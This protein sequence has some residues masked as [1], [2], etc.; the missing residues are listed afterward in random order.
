MRLFTVA[1]ILLIA[2]V[3]TTAQRGYEVGGWLGVSHYFG[4]LNT[5]YR[6]DR[7]GIAG[8]LIGRY[9]FNNRLSTKLSLNY[10]RLSAYDSDSDNPFQRARNLSFR[11]PVI[12]GT[13]QFEF[14][15]FPYEHGSDDYYFTP[16][17]FG[18]VSAYYSNPQAEYEGQ[19]YELQSLGTEGQPIGGEYVRVQPALAYGI[20][21][22]ADLNSTWSINV[23]MS[24][25][26]LFS[27]YLDDVSTV[28]PNPI[29][30]FNLR[31]GI[32]AALS[33]RSIEVV[34]DPIGGEGRQR[35]NSRNNDVFAFLQVGLVYYIGTLRCPTLSKPQ[36]K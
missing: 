26:A 5:T 10:G 25:R 11:S 12:D 36:A 35:G 16:Y 30:L 8:G 32:A 7:P 29:E 19:W 23:E 6:L 14:N 17:I 22:K 31:G 13:L 34:D 2:A 9:N 3:H 27:D 1:V 21:I 24:S 28:Y 33:D 4:D 20:G 15:F 18:G